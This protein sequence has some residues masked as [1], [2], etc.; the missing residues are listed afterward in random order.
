[1]KL[2]N[3]IL[4]ENFTYTAI[5]EIKLT[6]KLKH[7]D[8]KIMHYFRKYTIHNNNNTI[9]ILVQGKWAHLKKEVEKLTIIWNILKK[10]AKEELEILEERKRELRNFIR[11]LLKEG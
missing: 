5:F 2:K 1:M 6:Q 10:E 4:Q 9:Q 3:L 7:L 8:K 11:K